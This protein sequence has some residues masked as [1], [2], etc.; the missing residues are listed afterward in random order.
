MGGS[1][2][3]D[4]PGAVRGAAGDHEGGPKRSSRRRRASSG[5]SAAIRVA[6]LRARIGSTSSSRASLL[7]TISADVP[8]TSCSCTV[9]R[10]SSSMPVLPDR[11][12]HGLLIAC[13]LVFAI[14]HDQGLARE[15]T[16]AAMP[17]TAI[18]LW[19][20]R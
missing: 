10:N 3:T 19:Q 7:I 15:L 18:G 12:R 20:S 14:E 2:G 6:S 4:E 9:L 8:G 13:L 1:P 16:K 5:R 17:M 11:A